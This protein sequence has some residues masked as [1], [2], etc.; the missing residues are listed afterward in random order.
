MRF[1]RT[2]EIF[3]AFVLAGALYAQTGQTSGGQASVTQTPGAQTQAQETTPPHTWCPTDRTDYQSPVTSTQV[4][5]RN[6]ASMR[7]Q[8]EDAVEAPALMTEKEVA[9]ESRRAAAET[10]IKDVKRRGV[11]F[12]MTSVI[13]KKLRK[14]NAS[15]EVIE[16][17][18]QAGP[19]FRAQMAKMILGPGSVEVQSVPKEQARGFSLIVGE[20]D[21][22]KALT[23][24]ETF[25]KQFPRSPLLSYVYSLGA[26][27]YQQ[28]GDVEKVVG[29][30]GYSLNFNPDNLTSLIMRVG[31]LPQPQY[32]RSHAAYRGEILQETLSDANHA[33][34][35]ISQI[36]KQSNETDAGYRQR[37]A[38]FA[39]EIH[40]P[41]GMAHLELASAGPAG[42]DKAELAKA[43]QEFATAVSTSSH[44][45]PR[46]Y[47]RLGEAYGLDEKWDDAIQAFTKAGKLG[48]GTLIKNYAYEQIA[49]IKKRKAQGMVA[50]NPNTF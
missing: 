23:L 10:V 6:Q 18:R 25:T 36:P 45:D 19:K 5:I 21:P 37:L 1:K 43:E 24:V 47:Y 3:A 17:T 9:S 44:P 14:A 8:L 29:Y 22:D 50:S 38:D 12:D 27:A 34:Q 39:G 4:Q 46:D 31:M 32:L 41:L 42:L 15:D 7:R 30:T 26:N 49:Q 16:A 35:L 48:Q 40:G 33:L 28:K 2:L 11:D 13:E 20:S